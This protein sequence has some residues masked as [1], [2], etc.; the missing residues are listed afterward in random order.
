MTSWKVQA[1]SRSVRRCLQDRQRPCAQS[2][3][4]PIDCI[5]VARLA[6]PDDQ[7][8]PTQL[9]EPVRFLRISCNVRGEL[10]RPEGRVAG[11]RGRESAAW[12]SVP[13]AAV[14]EERDARTWKHD[15]RPTRQASGV[16]PESQ[17]AGMEIAP[18]RHLRCGIGTPDSRHHPR[19]RR[20]VDGIDHTAPAPGFP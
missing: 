18:D 9:L 5:W 6:L 16:Q 10:R 13:E 7:R 12:V 17:A 3:V 11:R 19:A 4:Q 2:P 8:R 1:S 20:L 15:V 14:D